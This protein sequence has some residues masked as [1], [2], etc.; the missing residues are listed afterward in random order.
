M[1]KMVWNKEML[2]H[3]RFLTLFK[4][5]AIRKVQENLLG[6]KLNGT[7]HL[8]AYAAY[9][10]PLGD[11]INTI[12]KK[13]QTLTDASKEVGLGINIEKSK[14]VLLSRHQNVAKN[15]DMKIAKR[16][17]ENASQ[18]KYLGMRVTN[19][20]LIQ[21]EVKRRLNSGNACYH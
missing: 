16:P 2:Y 15:G 7:H 6:L 5:K 11:N 4:E 20:N 9:A 10:N 13:T 14:Y 21:E 1:S 12:D 18:F 8:L 17:F 19:E 3:H